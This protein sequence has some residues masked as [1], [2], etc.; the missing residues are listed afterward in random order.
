[1]HPRKNEV[2]TV[3]KVGVLKVWSLVELSST[4]NN[5]E[6]VSYDQQYTWTT[7]YQHTYSEEPI[8]AMSF[9][10]DGSVYA[11]AHTRTVTVWNALTHQLLFTM[12]S[13]PP[14]DPVIK[15]FLLYCRYTTCPSSRD[16]RYFSQLPIIPSTYGTPSPDKSSGASRER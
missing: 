10:F 1:V 4:Q 8:L 2:T 11:L 7:T 15:S 13:P 5:N 9:A 6:A 14:H 12:I 16:P 3:D